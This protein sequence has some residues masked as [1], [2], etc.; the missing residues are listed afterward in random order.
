[1]F[2]VLLPGIEEMLKMA[3]ATEVIACLMSVCKCGR[4]TKQYIK[5]QKEFE[6]CED[7]AITIVCS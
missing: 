7:S 5:A 4:R 1:M 6:I 2:P 3:T